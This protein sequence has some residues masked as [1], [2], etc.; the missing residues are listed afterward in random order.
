M[1]ISLSIFIGRIMNKNILVIIL[2]LFVLQ[3]ACSSGSAAT[4]VPPTV[5]QTIEIVIEPT[6]VLIAESTTQV[7]DTSYANQET[8][9]LT[10]I[11]KEASEVMPST[12]LIDIL[13]N[14]SYTGLFPDQPI[15]LKDGYYYYSEGG[16]GTPHVRLVDH[17]ILIGDLNEDGAQDAVLMLEDD[18][19]GTGRFTYLGA[20][21][22]VWTEPMPVEAI[23][24]GD[25]IGV[26]SLSLDGTQII[27]DIVAQGLGD[28]E[29]CASWNEQVVY[30]LEN[31]NL[32]ESNRKDLSRISLDDLN[33]SQWRLI[34]LG[35]D[36]EL[37]VPESEITLLFENN[38]I[39]G[40]SG[41]NDYSGVVTSGEYGLN[42]V[43]FSPTTST[44]KLCSDLVSNQETNYLKNLGSVVAWYYDYGYLMLSYKLENNISGEF[45]F[46][47]MEE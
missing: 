33:H 22:N 5:T 11:N 40:F 1:G 4:M 6:T 3:T 17:Q 9:W 35:T 26:K 7:T 41:C 27:A 24:I 16:T 18:S 46:S 8:L 44:G 28:P 45:L 39:S 29:C 21:L 13:G 36:Q 19:E 32:V 14:L 34:A 31:T 20:V 43:N 23:M 42:N 25:R 30:S 47:P 15:T 2:V 38:Q 37:A 10:P 12:K